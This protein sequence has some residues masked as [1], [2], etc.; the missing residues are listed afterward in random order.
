MGSN[1]IYKI[2]QEMQQKNLYLTDIENRFGTWNWNKDFNIKADD[3]YNE[4]K[5]LDGK[6]KEIFNKPKPEEKKEEKKD[7]KKGEK[8]VEKKEGKSKDSQDKKQNKQ[9]EIV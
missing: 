7:E 8:K 9:Q 5:Q 6:Y 1:E 4:A 2:V 3:L